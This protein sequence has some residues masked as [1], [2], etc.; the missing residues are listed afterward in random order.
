MERCL[1][2]TSS[3]PFL[4]QDQSGNAPTPQEHTAL[5]KKKERKK[6]KQEEG[7]E[8]GREWEEKRSLNFPLDLQSLTSLSWLC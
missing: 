4:P 7:E 2:N 8:E 5:E 3:T 6:K 1:F